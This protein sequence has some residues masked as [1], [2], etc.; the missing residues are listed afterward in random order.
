MRR[1]IAIGLVF[2]SLWLS[3]AVASQHS[4]RI[5]A[6]QTLGLVTVGMSVD[7]LMDAMGL[8]NWAERNES[9]N[10]M[11]VG[12]DE[13]EMIVALTQEGKVFFVTT[14]SA[15]YADEHGLKVGSAMSLIESHYGTNVKRVESSNDVTVLI[16][17]EHGIAFMVKEG[18]IISIGVFQRTQSGASI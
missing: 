1:L 17:K 13:K 16:Y 12:Y 11:D 4:Y 2:A 8:P 18:A 14:Y 9:L 5:V 10:I 6:G 15:K 3:V 7:T